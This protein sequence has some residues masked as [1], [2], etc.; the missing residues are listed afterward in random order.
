MR[1]IAKSPS[2]ARPSRSGAGCA[3]V[4]LSCHCADLALVYGKGSGLSPFRRV[5]WTFLALGPGDQ[6]IGPPRPRQGF[7]L[8]PAPGRDPGMV[9]RQQDLRDRLALEL[10][11]AGILRVFQ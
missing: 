7:G 3:S 10:L 8:G 4:P 6:E 11:G 2:T 9:P 1:F 5:F